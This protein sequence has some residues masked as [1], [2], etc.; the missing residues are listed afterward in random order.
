MNFNPNVPEPYSE[1]WRKSYRASED[2]APRFSTYQSPNGS[3]ISFVLGKNDFSGG[4]SVDTSEY[5][6][7]GFWSNNSLNEKPQEITINGFVR[8]EN[9]I[10]KRNKLVE[11]LRVKTNDDEPGYL[12]L[13]LWG[14][15]AVVVTDWRIGEDGEKAGECDLSLTF[16]RAGV[17]E[18]KRLSSSNLKVI[19]IS[20]LTSRL[21]SAAVEDFVGKVSSK[22]DTETLTSGFEKFKTSLI[23]TIGRIQGVKSKLNEITKKCNAITNLIAQ[24]IKNPRELALSLVSAF[25]GIVSG[26]MEIQTALESYTSWNSTYSDGNSSENTSL[27]SLSAK[28]NPAATIRCFLSSVDTTLDLECIT[29]EQQNTKKELE[30]LN[31]T[32]SFCAAAEILCE[33]DTGTYQN[34]QGLWS[35]LEK[36]EDSLDL[37]NSDVYA[38]VEDLRIATVQTLLERNAKMELS[39]NILSA[40]PLLTLSQTLGCDEKKIRK[41]N[42]VYDSFLMSG[43]VKYV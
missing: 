14:R 1:S 12:D 15:F 23:S 3:P 10:A 18:S 20:S 7:F 6:Y 8:G 16:R 13:P 39:K 31:R 21:Q 33:F 27:S 24:G 5:P 30:N 38:A 32:L 35:L 4:Q 43:E 29:E 40:T 19:D 9:Y 28:N 42:T 22:L 36:L 41:M 2:D 11:A 34:Q 37:E 17:S 25:S 26:L